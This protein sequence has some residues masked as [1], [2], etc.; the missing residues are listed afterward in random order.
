[1][2]ITCL[3]LIMNELSF[4][5]GRKKGF[6][7][8]QFKDSVSSIKAMKLN[9]SKIKDRPVVLDWAV[10]KDRFL[11]QGGKPVESNESMMDTSG[12]ST[13]V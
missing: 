13:Q 5:D 11:Q 3:I 7:F 4:V 10:S 8:I 6:G 12:N 1:M 9:G 2:K